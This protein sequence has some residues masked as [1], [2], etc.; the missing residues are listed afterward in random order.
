MVTV[1]DK[2]LDEETMAQLLE[3]LARAKEVGAS[4]LV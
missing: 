4:N 1:S 2:C 3:E